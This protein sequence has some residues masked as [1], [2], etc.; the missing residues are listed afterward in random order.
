MEHTVFKVK[1]DKG[2]AVENYEINR[3]S[4][5][6]LIKTNVLLTYNKI[7]LV[8]MKYLAIWTFIQ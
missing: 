6:N 2:K 8:V 3:C 1:R 4:N 5:L 7:Y